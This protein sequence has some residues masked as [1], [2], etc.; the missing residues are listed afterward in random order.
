MNILSVVELL[1]PVAANVAD[2]SAEFDELCIDSRK[3]GIPQDTLFF[4]IRTPKND[5]HKYIAQLAQQGVR[6]FVVTDPAFQIPDCN[7]IVVDNAVK[8]LQMQAS[9]HRQQFHY[10]VI[11]SC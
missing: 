5:G 3:L 2:K 1:H 11:G 7:F 9:A 8:A 10:P 6:N 4:A